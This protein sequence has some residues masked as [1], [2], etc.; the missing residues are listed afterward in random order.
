MQDWLEFII[1]I[2]HGLIFL[3]KIIA[4]S[5]LLLLLTL[6]IFQFFA[7]NFFE[8]GFSQLDTVARHLILFIIF[9]GAALVSE[10]NRHIKIDILTP[11]L[12][13]EQQQ[14]LITPIFLFSSIISAVFCWYSI[15]FWLDEWQYAP[16]N[17]LWSVYLALILPIG[18]FILAL[19]LLLLTI[20][21][22]EISQT[23]TL[24]TILVNNKIDRR[25]S[26]RT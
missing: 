13:T 7:R 17:E 8:L 24:E 26:K 21:G 15:I 22:F 1:K 2:K 12:S 25:F 20:S 16:V 9:M 11:F 5:S 3:E 19:H 10:Q 6:A 23:S 18:F 14:K 4:A